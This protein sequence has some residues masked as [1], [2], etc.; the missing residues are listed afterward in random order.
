MDYINELSR[1][2]A[3]PTLAIVTAFALQLASKAPSYY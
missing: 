2:S 1:R 3:A